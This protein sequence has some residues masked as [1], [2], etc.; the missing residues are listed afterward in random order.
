MTFFSIPFDAWNERFGEREVS[1]KI[2]D[3]ESIMR[4]PTFDVLDF[5]KPW[6]VYGLE[7][8]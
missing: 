6:P 8:E 3:I 1:G 4:S 2:I 5:E 7:E